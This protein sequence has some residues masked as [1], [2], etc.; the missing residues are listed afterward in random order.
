MCS[1][2]SE[3]Q[4]VLTV[5]VFLPLVCVIQHQQYI[6]TS[7][8]F[9]WFEKFLIC[10]FAHMSIHMWGIWIYVNAVYWMSQQDIGMV[11]WKFVQYVHLYKNNSKVD[12]EIMYLHPTELNE[13]SWLCCSLTRFQYTN[14]Y[15]W[16]LS[17]YHSFKYGMYKSLVQSPQLYH[18]SFDH[19]Q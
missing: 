15:I 10:N 1:L 17:S 16:F 14:L 13:I 12:P 3:K 19:L 8:C 7:L 2:I 5:C 11:I 6:R 18:W 4:C 9:G